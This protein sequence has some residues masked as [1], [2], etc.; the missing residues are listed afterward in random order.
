MRYLKSY[1][2]VQE[3][4]FQNLA[5]GLGLGAAT[6][7]S[8][9][10]KPGYEYEI[11]FGSKTGKVVDN[12][13]PGS[14]VDYIGDKSYIVTKADLATN[15]EVSPQWVFS[16]IPTPEQLSIV[17]SYRNYK[18]ELENPYNKNPQ[19]GDNVVFYDLSDVKMIEKPIKNLSSEQP[20][21][22]SEFYVAA[23][24]WCEDNW[25]VFQKDL[26]QLKLSSVKPDG[27]IGQ[28]TNFNAT[29]ILSNKDNKPK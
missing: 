16:K 26:D 10:E 24:K 13:T 3:S 1:K 25:E 8:S 27:L 7:T 23:Y 22:S 17:A 29:S 12:N 20:I 9:C 19:I 2:Q 5:V 15:Y 6:L 28:L 18:R 21:T 14:Q 11:K 4:K